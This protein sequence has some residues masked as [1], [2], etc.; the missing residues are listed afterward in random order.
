VGASPVKPSPK[1]KRRFV[2]G[3]SDGTVSTMISSHCARAR[4]RPRSRGVLWQIGRRGLPSGLP[5]DIFCHTQEHRESFGKS[6]REFGLFGRSEMKTRKERPSRNQQ[7]RPHG[8]REK[9][10]TK[11]KVGERTP[12]LHTTPP[13]HHSTPPSLHHSITP[14]LHHSITPSLHHSITPTRR[15]ADT[16]TRFP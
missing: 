2:A 1:M 3:G 10:E 6:I 15:H 16:P 4:S 12:T 5:I 14:S 9:F 11:S 7:S 8:V 13:L